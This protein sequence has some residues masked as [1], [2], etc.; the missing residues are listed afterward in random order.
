MRAAAPDSLESLRQSR[1]LPVL[2][3]GN[4]R[5]DLVFARL[6]IELDMIRRARRKTI[7]GAAVPVA[8][9]EDLIWMK[10]LSERQ[11][12]IEDARRLLRRHRQNLDR[13]HLE[14]RLRELAEALSR[15]EILE[16]YMTEAGN[17]TQGIT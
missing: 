7:A 16:I 10:L 14:P 1:V 15:T 4:V 6:P 5:V 9:L 12:D 11:Q 2:S 13:E 17:F 3:S 8:S